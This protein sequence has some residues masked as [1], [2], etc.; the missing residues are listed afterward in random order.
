MTLRMIILNHNGFLKLTTSYYKVH[1]HELN[2]SVLELIYENVQRVSHSHQSTDKSS[3]FSSSSS[4]HQSRYIRL[5]H[6][7]SQLGA[8]STDTVASH[9]CQTLIIDSIKMSPNWYSPSGPVYFVCF[10][11]RQRVRRGVIRLY[12]DKKELKGQWNKKKTISIYHLLVV[13]KEMVGNGNKC[14]NTANLFECSALNIFHYVI[15][16]SFHF[17]AV[18]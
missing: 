12:R 18:L 10:I 13:S 2:R 1:V 6:D 11:S 15:W 14:L 8:L 9:R 3:C 7:C 4:L 16:V 5:R 17:F